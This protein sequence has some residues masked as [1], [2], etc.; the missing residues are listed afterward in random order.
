MA[1]RFTPPFCIEVEFF[2]KHGKPLE[3]HE[4]WGDCPD[5]EKVVYVVEDI[6]G[7]TISTHNTRE[8]AQA[9]LEIAKKTVSISPKPAPFVR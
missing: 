3:W 4:C 7:Q 6:Y 2:D 1:K 9:A 8:K 5:A